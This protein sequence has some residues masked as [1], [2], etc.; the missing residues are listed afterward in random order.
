MPLIPIN[1]SL[2]PPPAI[3]CSARRYQGRER[4]SFD[5]VLRAYVV[6]LEWQAGQPCRCVAIPAPLVDLHLHLEYGP[7][8]RRSATEVIRAIRCSPL[9]PRLLRPRRHSQPHRR[10]E[11]PPPVHRELTFRVVG[12]PSRSEPR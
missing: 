10:G 8:G 2:S 4:E 5:G 11:L 7:C 12:P 1:S 3:W 6:V 9:S